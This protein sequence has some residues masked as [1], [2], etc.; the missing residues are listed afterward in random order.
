MRPRRMTPSARSLPMLRAATD[1][2]Q[3]RRDRARRLSGL[4]AITPDLADT[5]D[6]VAR[7]EAAAIGGASAIQYRNKIADA[8]LRRRQA[9]ALAR[10]A[11]AHRVLLVIN[12]DPALSMAVDADGVHVGREDGGVEAARRV[13][14]PH[15][16]VGVSCYDSFALA[17][18][19]VAAGAD[20]V[21]FG[22]FFPSIVKPDA[23]RADPSLLRRAAAL[24]VPVVAIGG[25]YASNVGEIVRAGASAAAV[26][27]AVFDAPDVEAAAGAIA[28][29]F[30]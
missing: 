17:E 30:G 13:V 19:A 29:A 28:A 3:A 24:G 5:D 12:D 27:S 14:G 23:C 2:A 11:K 4:Y 25:I 21:A 20:Y 7:V 9:E 18:N 22:S 16:I 6:L 26:I 10:V 15:R 1:G 8:A